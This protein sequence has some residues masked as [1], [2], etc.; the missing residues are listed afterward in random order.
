MIPADRLISPEDQWRLE[1]SYGVALEYSS[2]RR[3]TGGIEND[4]FSVKA[5]DRRYI[6]RAHDRSKGDHVEFE[7]ELL[8]SMK[9]RAASLQ[10]ALPM[11]TLDG[12]YKVMGSAGN[13]YSVQTHVSNTGSASTNLNMEQLN[14]VTEALRALHR[15]RSL[16]AQ[17]VSEEFQW[18]TRL[19][20]L[21]A[22]GAVPSELTWALPVL[23]DY[24]TQ[25]SVP[26][27]FVPIHGDVTPENI[28]TF[29][30]EP[31]ALIDFDDAAVGPEWVDWA[32]LARSFVF[33]SFN[34][35]D[36]G[37]VSAVLERANKS[38][39]P[40]ISLDRFLGHIAYACLRMSV[41]VA[42]VL[43]Q[44]L[45]GWVRSEDTNRWR[46]VAKWME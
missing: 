5:R 12:S 11:K 1:S 25:Y 36:F 30:G 34:E 16:A 45:N 4:V 38:G 8:A 14:L 9:G 43:K 40:F 3:L 39:A 6:L 35:P 27:Q 33:S 2:L 21:Y 10:L 26:R 17:K 7:G 19:E 41:V 20:H 31:V 15:S 23:R 22:A 24:L 18:D 42:G 44:D 28:L 32:V 13:Y 29:D 37:M 46:S